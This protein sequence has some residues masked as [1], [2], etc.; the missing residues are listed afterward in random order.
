MLRR[1]VIGAYH[2]YGGRQVSLSSINRRFS[3][4]PSGP[5][6]VTSIPGPKGQQLKNELSTIEEASGVM[7]FVDY[8]RS[9]GNY[10]VD[11]DGN[12]FLDVYSQISSIPLGYNHPSLAK[13][14]R[15]PANISTFI[16]RPALGVL[17]PKNLGEQL[18]NTLMS[19]APKGLTCIQTMACGSCSVENALKA[20]CFWYQGKQRKGAP[21]TAEELESSLFNIPPG[22]PKLSI[23][24]FNGGFHGRTFGAL[25][26]THSKPIHKLDVP[27]F[28]WPMAPFPRYRY[29]LEEHK[30]ENDKVDQ[31]CLARVEELIDIYQKKG[32]PVAGLIVEPIQGEGGDNHGSANFFS[33]IR[34]IT[35]EKGVAFIVDEVQTGGGP[36]GKFWAHEHWNLQDPPDIITFSKKMLLGGFFY[37]SEFRPD[38]PFRIFNTWLGD[39]SKVVLLEAVLKEIKEKNLL[40]SV[41]KTGKYLLSGLKSLESKYPSFLEAARGVGTFAAIDFKTPALRDRGVKELHLNGVHCGGSGEKTLRIRTTLTFNQ[42]HVDIFLDKFNTVL[43][44][45]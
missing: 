20:A 30:S 29:P 37:R 15:D 26:C 7:M 17:P 19:V 35:K 45:W 13:V 36:T 28:D 40:D 11:V 44:K 42:K 12:T 6:V 16:N 23:M 14:V 34:K 10:I 3:S 1:V 4:E 27:S 8:E 22:A 39:P 41:K 32:V 38:A 2:H 5:S 9:F 24:S 21:P 18:K 31:E 25:S 43:S 33:G